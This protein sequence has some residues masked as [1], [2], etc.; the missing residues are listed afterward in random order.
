MDGGAAPWGW[1]GGRA[2]AGAGAGRSTR[3]GAGAGAGQ[4]RARSW[5]PRT[6]ASN[7]AG[8][9]GLEFRGGSAAQGFRARPGQGVESGLGSAGRP[10]GCGEVGR[11]LT[12]ERPRGRGRAPAPRRAARRPAAARGD[13]PGLRGA[14]C[15]PRAPGAQPAGPG[16]R[17]AAAG[18]GRR[19]A[20][21]RRGRG[22]PGAA[23][24]AVGPAG[25]RG[26]SGAAVRAAV[27][28]GAGAAAG[29]PGRAGHVVRPRRGGPVSGRPAPRPGSRG[30]APLR[31][32]GSH[33]PALQSEASPPS[34]KDRE[35]QPAPAPQ[36]RPAGATGPAPS[37]PGAALWPPPRALGTLS[38]RGPRAGR[39]GPP[40]PALGT[41]SARWG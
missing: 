35:S 31:L 17:G 40:R 26:G 14:P 25:A 1:E 4:G 11:A 29:A 16:A 41:Q 10:R 7:P 19:A 23:P 13:G 21:A 36:G 9:R 12:P 39:P 34:H 24:A 32:L 3:A 18:A 27:R 37:R 30:P 33:R 8:G 38:P 15:R 5:V 28:G 2:R 20:R 22:A 6:V